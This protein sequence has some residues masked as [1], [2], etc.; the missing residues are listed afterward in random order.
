[1]FVADTINFREI[2]TKELLPLND[3]Q[4]AVIEFLR[5]RKDVVLAGAQAVNVYVADA[6]MS[7][8]VDVFTT[9]AADFAEELRLHLS[10]RF[11]ILIEAGEAISGHRYQLV[12]L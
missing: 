2:V 3:I 7:N 12:E 6:R 9:C 5:G 4:H 1:M 10:R 11:H 8:D